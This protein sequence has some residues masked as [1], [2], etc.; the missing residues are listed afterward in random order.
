MTP[1]AKFKLQFF[2]RAAVIGMLDKASHAALRKAGGAIRLFAQR[3]MRY[4]KRGSAAG[5]A[6]SAHREHGAKLRKLVWFAFDEGTRSVVVGPLPFGKGE[7]PGVEEFGG[8][9][10]RSRRV[11]QRPGRKAGA[12]Q[13]AAF[14]RKLKAG[15]IPA[16][17]APQTV[18]M[19]TARYPARPYMGPALKNEI[20]KMPERWRNS[21]TVNGGQ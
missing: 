19:A 2:D 12:A 5:E 3:S 8:T 13:S 18:V 17:Q 6:P 14:K 11:A 9:V 20:P 7:A 21:A 4:R 1:T 16:G 15:A 10:T